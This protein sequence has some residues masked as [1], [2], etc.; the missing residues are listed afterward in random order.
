MPD[1]SRLFYIA[2]LRLNLREEIQGSYSIPEILSFTFIVELYGFIRQSVC[3]LGNFTAPQHGFPSQLGLPPDI[4]T[5][6]N[7][8]LSLIE[9][10]SIHLR[11]FIRLATPTPFPT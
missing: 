11:L 6:F 10:L 9:Q 8:V 5:S 2:D 1:H 4:G 3:Y 7:P